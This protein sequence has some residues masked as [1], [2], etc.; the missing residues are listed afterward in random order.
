MV[1]DK[2]EE[3]AHILL[4]HTDSLDRSLF[5]LQSLGAFRIKDRNTRANDSASC[6]LTG[7][8]ENTSFKEVV[9]H[10]LNDAPLCRAF[11]VEGVCGWN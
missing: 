11:C 10:D 3:I 4:F 2:P 8:S 9:S 5:F 1:F 6:M 7:V